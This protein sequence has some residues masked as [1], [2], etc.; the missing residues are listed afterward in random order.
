[1]GSSP[2]APPPPDPVATSKAQTASN[3]A[4]ATAN[5]RLSNANENG[6]L[7]SVRYEV[8]SY[9]NMPDGF[10]GSIAVPKY[11]RIE[12]LSPEQQKL[13]DQQTQL[14]YKM[15]DLAGAQIDR[16]NTTMSQP[17]NTDGLPDAVGDFSEYQKRT[18]AA[19]YDRLNPQLDRE[20][21]NLE[22]RLESQGLQRGTQAFTDAMNQYGSQAND[23]RTSVLLAS[24]QETREMAAQQATARERA[25][26]E[27][28]AIRNQPLNEISTL[29]NG[30]QVTM[31]QFTPYR[32]GTVSDTDYAGNVYKSAQLAQDAWKT[33]AAQ[34]TAMTNGLFNLGGSIAGGL[35][36]LSDDRLK[37]DIERIG[38]LP[39]GI[40]LYKYRMKWRDDYEVGVLA[41]EVEQIM[42]EAVDRSGLFMRVNYAMVA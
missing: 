11:N 28:L 14:G 33:Q 18:E 22:S 15:N 25:L 42:P 40:P 26:Q 19:L 29:M 2:K 30:G 20:R 10:G 34:K 27:R 1:M 6:P 21:A 17:I 37:T 5:S 31:P 36:K 9:E 38:T 32:S 39:N 7:G 35:F 8:D 41:Q 12:T 16:L 3:V 4:T 13:Y 23:A 24:G